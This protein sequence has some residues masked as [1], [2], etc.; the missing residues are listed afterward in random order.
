MRQIGVVTTSRADY[1]LLRPV[2]RAV[3][4][5]PGLRPELFVSGSHLSARHGHTVDEIVADRFPIQ[6]RVP[7]LADDTDDARGVAEAMGRATRGMGLALAE[8]R[9]DL[10]LVLGDRFEMLACALAAVP[11]AIPIAHIHGGEITEGAMDEQFRHALSKLAHLHFPATEAFA[12]RLRQMGE[13]PWRILVGGAPG[14]D[15]L[16]RTVPATPDE[17]RRRFGIDLDPPP[18]LVTLHPET[19]ADLPPEAQAAVLVE[20]LTAADRPCVLTGGNADPGGGVI[21]RTL[22][23]FAEHRPDAWRVDHLGTAAYVAL[24]THATAMVGN[25]SSGIIEAA[26]FGLPVI[27][28]GDRQTGRPRGANVLDVPFDVDAIATAISQAADPAFRD[29]LESLE[30]P[31]GDGHAGARIA[32][33]LADLPPRRR[34]LRKAFVDLEIAP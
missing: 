24:M 17:L 26:S 25:S 16:A 34:L 4:E 21:D 11:L 8:A 27:N 15:A 18:L 6:A 1:G 33:R 20:A 23:A 32:A 3:A 29:A 31:Y 30:N 22:S 13:E 2:I 10:L 5:T 14:L 9:P 19:L 28:I 7:C 12:R